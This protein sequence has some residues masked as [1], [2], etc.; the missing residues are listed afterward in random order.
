[1]GNEKTRLE[2]LR[3]RYD[4]GDKTAWPELARLLSEFLAT[5]RRPPLWLARIGAEALEQL[6]AIRS[7]R[8]RPGRPKGSITAADTAGRKRARRYFDLRFEQDMPSTRAA[9]RV[10]DENQTTASQ[11]FKDARRHEA[12]LAAECSREADQIEEE[13]RAREAALIGPHYPHK[14]HLFRAIAEALKPSKS[15]K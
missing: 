3:A 9:N 12:A 7:V 15:S 14:V 6:A 11:I 4:V 13:V 1:M 2:S 8:G 5:G 10:A